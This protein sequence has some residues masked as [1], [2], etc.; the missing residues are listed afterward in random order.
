[1][2]PCIMRLNG[3]PEEMGRQQ[4]HLL[5]GEIHDRLQTAWSW[6]RKRVDTDS[7]KQRLEW[8]RL[9]HEMVREFQQWGGPAWDEWEA[10][11]RAA[12]VSREELMLV[13]AW[14]D[15]PEVWAARLRVAVGSGGCT[16]AVLRPPAVEAGVWLA[17]NWDVPA[18]LGQHLHVFYRQPEDGPAALVLAGAGGF[19][20]AGI[21][22]AGLSFIWVDRACREA[23]PRVPTGAVL[24]EVAHMSHLDAAVRTIRETPRA[25]GLA[26]ALADSSGHATVLELAGDR[27]AE[28][29]LTRDHC[30]RVFANHYQAA[31]LE[32]QD[33]WPNRPASQ[34]REARLHELLEGRRGLST[35]EDLQLAFADHQANTG[36]ALCQHQ[37][38]GQRTCAF[39]AVRIA[40]RELAFTLGPPC[41][42]ELFRQVLC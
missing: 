11:A 6:W 31:T 35:P 30:L 41:Q 26:V 5:K 18:A 25:S 7:R 9:V 27:V 19:P 36:E 38:S 17:M 1:M 16:A 39:L 4:G 28:H 21:N 42:S 40:R 34:G 13:T 3:S 2:M 8:L 33:A 24:L 20:I 37:E 23:Q 22:E 14:H 15:W 29:P 10:L 12:Q 32:P